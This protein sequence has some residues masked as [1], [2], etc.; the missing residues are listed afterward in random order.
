VYDVFNRLRHLVFCVTINIE[1]KS[2]KSLFKTLIGL[3][4][5]LKIKY[6]YTRSTPNFINRKNVN[7]TII[8]CLQI[9]SFV[10]NLKWE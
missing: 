10:T 6:M 5:Q 1:Y 2:N 7:K 4:V 8:C 3:S 9:T